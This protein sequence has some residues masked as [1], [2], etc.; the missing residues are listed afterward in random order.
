MRTP[1][2]R[3]GFSEEI[4]PASVLKQA[5]VGAKVSELV[6]E[7]AISEATTYDW[8]AKYGGLADSLVRRLK[9]LE[10][11]TRQH[12]IER[13]FMQPGKPMQNGLIERFNRTCREEVLDCYVFE[14]LG[15]VRLMNPSA[16]LRHGSN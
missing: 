10:E 7:N 4:R 16:T 2:A 9:E 12:S 14:S 11:W 6:R 15:E 1:V 13:R 8:K 5:G 3:S